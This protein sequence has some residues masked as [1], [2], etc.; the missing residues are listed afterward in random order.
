MNNQA[1]NI[2]GAAKMV[3]MWEARLAEVTEAG[4]AFDVDNA[5]Q[6]LGYAKAR[7]EF[8]RAC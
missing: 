3:K 7:L 4:S 8:L 5:A 1:A 2:D 6:R